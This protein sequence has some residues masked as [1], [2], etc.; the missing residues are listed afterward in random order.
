MSLWSRFALLIIVPIV[1]LIAFTVTFSLISGKLE[2]FDLFSKIDIL[3]NNY[4]MVGVFI[5]AAILFFGFMLFLKEK[6]LG[7]S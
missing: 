1:I 3:T 6:F 4:L 2:P 5:L 7:S